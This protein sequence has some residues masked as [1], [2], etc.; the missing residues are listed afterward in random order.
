MNPEGVF[1]TMTYDKGNRLATYLAPG[2]PVPYT[3]SGGMLK[4]PDSRRSVGA[5]CPRLA[6]ARSPKLDCEWVSGTPT[7]LVWDAQN[8]LGGVS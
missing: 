4:R 2:S 1:T 5:R 6:S 3:Y 8:Y 7:T